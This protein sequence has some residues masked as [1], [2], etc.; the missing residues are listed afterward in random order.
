MTTS[1]I[2]V[3][4]ILILLSYIFDIK[5]SKIKVP[6][7]I[8]LLALGWLVKQATFFFEI[9]IPDLQPA[10]PI[11]G[12]IGLILIVLEGSLELEISKRKL[13][14]VGKSFI[15]A[16][17]AI[18][19]FS[20][21]LAYALHIV[22][23]IPLKSALSNAIP[24]GV[25]SSAIAIPSVQNLSN[26]NK[27]FITY[28][29]SLSD[30]VGVIFFNFIAMNEVIGLVSIANFFLN[31][32]IILVISFIATLGLSY[33]LSRI[34]HSVKYTPIIIMLI[35]IY[36]ISKTYHLPALLFIMLFGVFLANINKFKRY[37]HIQKLEPDILSEEVHKFGELTSEMAFLIRSLFFLLFG[38]L[39]KTSEL[40]N[41]KSILWAVGIC[42]LIY[43]IRLVLLKVFRFPLQP[44]LFIA[45][46]GLITILLFLSIPVS[47][48]SD[49]INNSLIIQVII[50]TSLIMMV[51]LMP[52]KKK[53]KKPIVNIKEEEIK[54]AE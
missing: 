37:K 23:G 8:L 41:T 29:S 5:S 31:M 13:P 53:P 7:V 52:G 28:E 40:L 42:A 32:L 1:I 26:R 39:V 47:A 16:F 33:L 15:I 45:P 4:C 27:E 48:H 50:L 22:D 6:S 30:I 51:G 2:I 14:F 9:E 17:L 38:F 54:P 44:L 25:I 24:L 3:I 21:G 10:L 12:T 35:L 19:I 34:T 46:R 11:L 36:V 49:L 18:I 43:S 20:I